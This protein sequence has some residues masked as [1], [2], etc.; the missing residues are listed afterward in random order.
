MKNEI[1]FMPSVSIIIPVH[2]RVD[3]LPETLN[4]VISQTFTDWECIVVDDHSTDHSLAVAESYAS[5]DMRFQA[6]SLP[7]PKQYA[8]A[9]RNYG[10]SLAKGQ[11]INFLDSDDLFLPDKIQLEL[12][13]FA[14]NPELDIVTCQ[15]ALI[16]ENGLHYLRFASEQFWLDVVWS[17]PRKDD[18]YG[19][20]WQ[21]NSSLWR[22]SS[23]QT[24]GCWDEQLRILQDV[25]LN[26]RAISFG[27]KIKRIEQVLVYVNAIGR[28]RI[29]ASTLENYEHQQKSILIAWDMIKRKKLDTDIR[30]KM[31]AL[32]L[33]LIARQFFSNGQVVKG[34]YLWLSGCYFTKQGGFYTIQG[35]IQLICM[36]YYHLQPIAKFLRR[37]FLAHLKELPDGIS[38]CENIL[39]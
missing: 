34:I 22:R 31:I 11:F 7:D 38:S 12:N 28:N 10:L 33:L 5:K 13:E 14:N 29:S 39:Y 9:A 35:I 18:R 1:E 2:N 6:I 32:R 20:L 36:H 4:S 27:L 16:E 3:V 23:I 21:T 25:E 15:H 37:F 24:I 17:P 19:G 8:N 30:R 26:I